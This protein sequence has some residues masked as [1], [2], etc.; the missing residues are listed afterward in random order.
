V[1]HEEISRSLQEQLAAGSGGDRFIPLPRPG[2]VLN[3]SVT[4]RHTARQVVESGR[5][6]F[7]G[8]PA[9]GTEFSGATAAG[10]K[11]LRKGF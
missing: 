5:F 9:G 2:R 4:D 10:E 3:Q 6:M 7:I 8:Y 11:A 1:L